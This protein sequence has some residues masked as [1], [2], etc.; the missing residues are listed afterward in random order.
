MQT[1]FGS[2]R[3]TQNEDSLIINN[4]YWEV[5]HS[6]KSGGCINSIKFSQGT[7]TNL[8][9]APCLSEIAIAPYWRG[10]DR[11]PEG[12]KQSETIYSDCNC[13]QIRLSR[14]TRNPK[15]V[16]FTIAGSLTSAAGD[17][18]CSYVH[19]YEYH[20]GFLKRTQRYSFEKEIYLMRLGLAYLRFRPELDR[21][22]YRKYTLRQPRCSEDRWGKLAFQP[23]GANIVQDFNVPFYIAVYQE[24][25]EGLEFFPGSAI[26]SWAVAKD[27]GYYTLATQHQ[28]AAVELRICPYQGSRPSLK[29]KGE[30][31]FQS[32]LGLPN[33]KR[34]I[35]R[36]IYRRVTFGC[37]NWPTDNEIKEL[38]QHGVYHAR[39]HNDGPHKDGRW[40]RDGSFPPY[41]RED[42][43]EMQRVIATAHK[44]KIKMM[45]YISPVEYHPEAQGF[46]KNSANWGRAVDRQGN[47]FDNY[48]GYLMC[49]KSG[50]KDFLIKYIRK[51]YRA[52][53]F[54]GVYFDWTIAL[55]CMNRLHAET[56]HTS[57]DGLLELIET[58]RDLVGEQGLITIHIW[59]WMPLMAVENYVDFVGTSERGV[60]FDRQGAVTTPY[61]VF[62]PTTYRGFALS[63][64]DEKETRQIVA[65]ILVSG[66]GMG[67]GFDASQTAAGKVVLAMY[68]DL[69]AI[70]TG[71][72]FFAD[73]TSG[74]VRIKHNQNV[75]GA[76]Y[77]NR[78]EAIVILA[79]TQ[80]DRAETFW[81]G[82]DLA[83]TG[84]LSSRSY[85]VEK[86]PMKKAVSLATLS[87]G[88]LKG[89]L[90]GYKYEIFHV[91][92]RA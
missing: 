70:K 89:R 62:V 29:F 77:W 12:K 78:K 24:R 55:G 23:A 67:L 27:A 40:W 45:F 16:G 14:L 8:L 83:R 50:W 42:T 88:G 36:D 86:R 13:H 7:N 10:V 33:I 85:L 35:N 44:H 73:Y 9:L 15:L 6:L 2:L 39:I 80:T 34:R 76:L 20:R 58:T 26:G 60:I 30:Y 1:K 43:R 51:I 11:S 28:P 84:L 90:G 92:P 41:N 5:E 54:D 82:L 69:Q 32:Y 38:R 17:A 47:L 91:T 57:I 72:Y 3:C 49:L 25:I 46:K 75:K 64:S 22:C 66:L 87:G 59:N 79:N 31:V 37:H 53:G 61:L 63:S 71:N 74:I 19:E 21:Y 56:E 52:Y 68:Q 65:R 81:W 48:Y 18:V 4:G